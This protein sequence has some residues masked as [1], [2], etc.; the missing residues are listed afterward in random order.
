MIE[1]SFSPFWKWDTLQE[2]FET[3]KSRVFP[4]KLYFISMLHLFVV[5]IHCNLKFRI[6]YSSNWADNKKNLWYWS[7]FSMAMT[8]KEVL[9]IRS[10]AQPSQSDF[11]LSFYLFIFILSFYFILSIK[12]NLCCLL[13]HLKIIHQQLFHW[14][15]WIQYRESKNNVKFI[16]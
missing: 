14:V 3:K 12:S 2:H 4:N 11:I 13:L 15:G 8:R 9:W 1:T 6:C 7:L 16:I 10:S 5:K